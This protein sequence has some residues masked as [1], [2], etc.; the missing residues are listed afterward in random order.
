MADLNQALDNY[1]AAILETE[2]Y[3]TYRTELEKVKSVPGLKEKI[4]DFRT[5]NF[6]LQSDPDCDFN[7]LDNLEREY[8]LFRED[9]LVSD[10]LAAEL[11]FCRL[12]Q[13]T[14]TYIAG[15]LDFE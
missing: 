2:E 1:I 10:F 13:S 4:D 12:L 14:N 3:R 11:A 8:D 15:K 7:K 6:L 9:V 5:R